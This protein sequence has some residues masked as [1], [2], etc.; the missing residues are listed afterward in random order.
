MYL[1]LLA[2]QRRWQRRWLLGLLLLTL[3]LFFCSLAWG[4]FVLLPWQPLGI[5]S[6]ASCW[7]CACRAPCWP[8]WRGGARLRWRRAAGDA[9][10]PGGRTRPARRLERGGIGRHGGDGGGQ[11][12]RRLSA[13]LGLSLAAFGGALLVTMLLIRLARRARLGHARLLLFGVAIGISPT[14]P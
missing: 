5:S 8:C 14:P 10:Q 7:S 9:A 3:A 11:G 12:P 13:G 4:E 6:S 2:R 1:S